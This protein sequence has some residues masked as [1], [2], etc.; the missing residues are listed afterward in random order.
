MPPRVTQ[1][2]TPAQQGPKD[3]NKLGLPQSELT[4]FENDWRDNIDGWTEMGIVGN[5]DMFDTT[6]LEEI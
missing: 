5:R 4:Q 3:F 1:F 2:T 6:L